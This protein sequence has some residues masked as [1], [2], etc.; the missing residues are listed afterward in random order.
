MGLTSC[1]RILFA[2]MVA[3][4]TGSATPA[5]P[6]EASYS[7]ASELCARGHWLEAESFLRN[8]LAKQA[9][10]SDD[11]WA[12]RVLYGQVLTARAKFPEA[13]EVLAPD[14]P[15]RL[16]SSV[17]AVR[18]FGYRAIALARAGQAREAA[19]NL[20]RAERLARARQPQL[21]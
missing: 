10:D 3:L 14:L 15:E 19:I 21:L 16:R 9:D 1:R 20:D 2:A 7:H 12:L 8:A 11:V 17:I 4:L 18:W 6:E 5:R 13:L